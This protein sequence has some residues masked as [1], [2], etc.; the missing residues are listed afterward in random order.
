MREWE[1]P[2]GW[3]PG[4]RVSLP[5]VPR[6]ADLAESGDMRAADDAI[7]ATA[8]DGDVVVGLSDAFG[9]NPGCRL[10][11]RRRTPS[12]A[13]RAEDDSPDGSSNGSLPAAR[14]DWVAAI[15]SASFP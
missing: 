10:A 4:E 7:R 2:P 14:R 11:E 5:A 13:R 8:G 12:C 6:S 1:A 3:D 9:G 15:Q